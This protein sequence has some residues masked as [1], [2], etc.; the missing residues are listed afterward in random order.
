MNPAT[1]SGSDAGEENRNDDSY[2]G[3]QT[4]LAE[5]RTRVILF[6]P[7]HDGLHAAGLC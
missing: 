1:S 2:E 4:T 5:G 6:L 3:A 7:Q